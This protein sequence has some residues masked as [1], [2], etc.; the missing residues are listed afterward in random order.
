MESNQNNITFWNSLPGNFNKSRKYLYARSNKPLTPEFPNPRDTERYGPY[1]Y[2]PA[3][4][5]M[6][7]SV[8]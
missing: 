3:V 5:N 8:S 1:D 2:N 7:C 4:S 6:V